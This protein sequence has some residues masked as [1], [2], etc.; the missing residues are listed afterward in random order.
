MNQLIKKP[1]ISEKSV[2]LA[3]GGKYVFIASQEANKKTVAQ[4][5][6]KL[7]KVK[8]IKVHSTKNPGK[9]KSFRR[10]TGKQSDKR[11][12]VVTLKKG[13]KIDIFEGAK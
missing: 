8:V 3:E 7:F 2:A 1:V 13:D 6:E 4:E 9:V 10:I 11:K 5:I 12:F